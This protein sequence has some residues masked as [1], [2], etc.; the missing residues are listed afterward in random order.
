MGLWAKQKSG[1]PRLAALLLTTSLAACGDSGPQKVAGSSGSSSSGGS[2]SGSGPNPA[3]F[4]RGFNADRNPYFGDLHVH[5]KYSLD[6]STQGTSLS[7]HDAYRFAL[8]ERVGIQPHDANGMPLRFTQLARPLDFAAVTDHAEFFGET[9]ICTNPIYLEYNSPECQF[10]RRDP[11]N[12]FIVFNA[13]LSGVGTPTADGGKTVNRFAYCGPG[14][15]TCLAAARTPWQDVQAAAESFYD[16]SPDCRFTSFVAYEWTGSPASNSL[17]RNVVF[18][19]EKVPMLPISFFDAAAPQFLWKGLAEQCKTAE[20]CDYLTIAHNSNLAGGTYFQTTDDSGAPY[21]RAFAEARQRNEPMA[22]IYQHKG[23]SECLNTMGA[24]MTD[25]ACGFELLPYNSLVGDRFGG[26][27]TAPPVERDFLREALKEG[28]LKEQQ[29]GANPFKYGFI[30]SSDTHIATPGNVAETPFPGHGG[31]GAGAR[32]ELPK[33]LTE[34]IEYSPGGLAVLWAEENT[35][36]SLW[37]ALKRKEAYGTSGTRPIV[38]FFGG[39]N[40][41]TDLCQQ[42]LA[43]RGY[44]L[45]VPM[46]GDLGAAPAGA[47]LRFA[48]SAL[49]DPGA[50][51]DRSQPL[52]QLQIIKGWV[53]ANGAKQERVLTVAGDPN[54][55]AT[56]NLS[57]CSTNGAGFASL[58]T[59]WEDASFNPNEAAFYYARVLENPSCRWSTLQCNAGG[60]DC[61]RPETVTEG[62]EDCCNADYPKTIQERAWTSPIWYRPAA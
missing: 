51:G 36:E 23:Q 31:N 1:W 9:E 42:G 25:E 29:L 57:D 17:H 2:S 38:R 52:Q 47:K 45:G 53:D 14:G 49:R 59:V 55:G 40:L 39:F 58:C 26:V 50:A 28:L 54:N 56:V 37:A 13:Q 32:T 3:G 8:G 5:T 7:P 48:V 16:R 34:A 44:A 22:E 12:A 30:G 60:V 43:R 11:D 46:G 41:P 20:G 33:G 21:D 15:A 24:G 10:Y 62:F 19:T 35:R 6:A 18:K 27:G 61:A 4:C